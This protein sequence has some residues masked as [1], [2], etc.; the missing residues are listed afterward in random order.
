MRGKILYLISDIAEKL[1]KQFPEQ[2]TIS[3]EIVD[4]ITRIKKKWFSK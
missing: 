1:I 2:A 4:K 3:M